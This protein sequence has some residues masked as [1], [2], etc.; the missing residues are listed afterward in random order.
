M[1]LQNEGG[2]NEVLLNKNNEKIKINDTMYIKV[3]HV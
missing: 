2:G 3:G 1:F